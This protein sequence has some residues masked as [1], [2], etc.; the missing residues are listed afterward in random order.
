MTRLKGEFTEFEK[1]LFDVAKSHLS[2]DEYIERYNIFKN[3]KSRF[4]D[5]FKHELIYAWNKK[6]I[7]STGS[8][9]L[10]YDA[11]VLP[12]MPDGTKTGVEL[13]VTRFGTIE[14]LTDAFKDHPRAD[15][16]LFLVW[17]NGSVLIELKK[18]CDDNKYV[19]LI[20]E[21]GDKWYLIMV[22]KHSDKI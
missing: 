4:E 5:W 19:Y 3:A 21:L 10:A 16:Y 6:G 7:N 12:I 13:R 2:Q 1:L 8:G 14:A 18:Y 15:R 17:D 22:K 20:Q 9:V 11:D